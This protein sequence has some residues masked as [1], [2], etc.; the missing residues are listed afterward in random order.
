MKDKMQKWEIEFFNLLENKYFISSEKDAIHLDF[1]LT[2]DG[3]NDLDNKGKKNYALKIYTA[4]ETQK[5]LKNICSVLNDLG[6]G[7]DVSNAY[8]DNSTPLISYLEKEVEKIFEKTKY[9]F[10]DEEFLAI[11]KNLGSELSDDIEMEKAISILNHYKKEIIGD[12]FIWNEELTSITMQLSD[13]D[14]LAIQ[15][16]ERLEKKSKLAADYLKQ[17]M[18]FKYNAAKG[19]NSKSKNPVLNQSAKDNNISENAVL[20]IQSAIE[21]NINV[22]QKAKKY[23]ENKMKSSVMKREKL[24]NMK[25]SAETAEIRF[26]YQEAITLIKEVF[27]ENNS[28]MLHHLEFLLESDALDVELR[29]EKR[30]G[31]FAVNTQLVNNSSIISVQYDGTLESVMTLAHEIGHSYHHKVLSQTSPLLSEYPYIFAETASMYAEDLVFEKLKYK[32]KGTEVMAQVLHSRIV[33]IF[34]LL[35]MV[36]SRFSFEQECYSLIEKN[37]FNL[38]NIQKKYKETTNY[39]YGE[40][41]GLESEN[42]WSLVRH[43]FFVENSYYNYP[44]YFGFLINKFISKN[45]N[46]RQMKD[47]LLKTGYT[48]ANK[49]FKD[50]FGQDLESKELWVSIV[51]E[52]EN[53]LE[54]LLKE[55]S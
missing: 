1:V 52:I 5:T 37:E 44:Y 55:M 14:G 24:R 17:I 20:A 40:S 50:S 39:W 21:E 45:N 6:K 12:K 15:I 38:E 28:E 25:C 16:K 27:K 32:F 49:C 11:E 51:E 42:G 10:E 48:D 54:D 46:E 53:E 43:Y 35:L 31:A 8:R 22:G 7:T 47:F 34:D 2:N 23:L 3:F 18:T 29:I 26:S 33:K 4:L 36:P 19:K 13:K 30:S 41:D 9:L